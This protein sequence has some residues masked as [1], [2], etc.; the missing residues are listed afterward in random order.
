M[1]VNQLAK[2]HGLAVA[3]VAGEEDPYASLVKKTIGPPSVLK[4]IFAPKALAHKDEK[5][6]PPILNRMANFF[7]AGEGLREWQ[8]HQFE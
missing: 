4:C 7:Y 2:K 6:Q 3:R 8:V 1:N 5:L